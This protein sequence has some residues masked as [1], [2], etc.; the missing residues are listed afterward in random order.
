MTSV[1]VKQLVL[2]FPQTNMRA[3]KINCLSLEI[4][5]IVIVI[6]QVVDK[7]SR[8]W[9]FEKILLWTEISMEL[10][11]DMFFLA[12]SNMDIQL[13]EKKLVWKTYTAIEVLFTTKRVELIDKK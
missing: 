8:A 6:I 12:L 9:F 11:V 10:V 3:R 13:L 5:K 7:V 1:F 2:L 4:F